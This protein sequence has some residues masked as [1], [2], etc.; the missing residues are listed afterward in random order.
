MAHTT[1]TLK[2]RKRAHSGSALGVYCEFGLGSALRY[3]AELIV[4]ALAARGRAVRGDAGERLTVSTG[5]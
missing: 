3:C 2:R 4:P 1:A 5:R